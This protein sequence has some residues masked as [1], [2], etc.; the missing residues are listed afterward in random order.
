M[1]TSCWLTLCQFIRET[2]TKLSLMPIPI[3]ALTAYAMAGDR[4]KCLACGMT[5]YLTKPMSK[6][7]PLRTLTLVVELSLRYVT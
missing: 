2:E 1:L 4:E 5:D 7:V 6:Q 3:I